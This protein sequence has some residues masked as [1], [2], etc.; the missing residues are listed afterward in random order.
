MQ[1]ISPP[2]QKLHRISHF[3]NPNHIPIR[4]ANPRLPL[5]PP[6]R[7]TLPLPQQ[8]PITNRRGPQPLIS[9]RIRNPMQKISIQFPRGH[10]QTPP[11]LQNAK[12]RRRPPPITIV[13]II[14]MPIPSLLIQIQ[15]NRPAQTNSSHSRKISTP[16]FMRHNTLTGRVFIN[17][18]VI[19]RTMRCLLEDSQIVEPR[20]DDW[21]A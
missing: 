17:Q 9:H 13:I 5:Q 15:H 3:R 18:D 19:R 8:I 11:F 12:P 1:F 10:Q 2:S 14:T 20:G 21:G 16:I 4:Q 6:T 7:I